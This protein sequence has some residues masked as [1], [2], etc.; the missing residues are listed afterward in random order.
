MAVVVQTHDRGY[1]GFLRCVGRA[2]ILERRLLTTTAMLT[3]LVF[4]P[5]DGDG[6]NSFFLDLGMHDDTVKQEGMLHG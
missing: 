2:A 4:L 6:R 1:Q 3:P 5:H